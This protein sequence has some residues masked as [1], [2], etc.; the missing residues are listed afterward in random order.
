MFRSSP[1]APKYIGK[2]S[3]RDATDPQFRIV[4]ANRSTAHFLSR[5]MVF[6]QKLILLLSVVL[7]ALSMNLKNVHLSQ[8]ATQGCWEFIILMIIHLN[9][10]AQIY[11]VN[12]PSM[13]NLK[14]ELVPS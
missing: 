3:L 12:I 7:W 2:N 10:K 8:C 11:I 14:C 13:L 6:S 4:S 1:Q 9:G 5:V